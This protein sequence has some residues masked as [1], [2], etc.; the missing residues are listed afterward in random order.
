METVY[1]IDN[2]KQALQATLSE[3]RYKH[4][5]GVA[6]TAVEM[7][8]RFGA[9]PEKAYLAGLLH[10]CAKEVPE[11]NRI[12]LC[13]KYHILVND[14]EKDN[15]GLLH[16]KMGE[17]MAKKVYKIEDRDILDAI[18]THTTGMPGMTKL[19]AIIYVADFI[20]PSRK[21]I[22][23]L[24]EIRSLAKEDLDKTVY[25]LSKYLLEFL[26]MVKPGKIDELSYQT[27]RYYKEKVKE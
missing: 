12:P 11:Q 5:L 8:K 21:D 3:H 25:Y 17:V 4:S 9:D 14:F 2:M 1:S 18:R 26:E 22:S 24:E 6:D 20:E 16:G 15:T 27:C 7:A 13:E 23:C 10:D 19:Q